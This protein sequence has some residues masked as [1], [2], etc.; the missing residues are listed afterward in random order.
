MKQF[1]RVLGVVAAMALLNTPLAMAQEITIATGKPGGGYD[2]RARDMA[3]R[4]EQ[5][6]LDITVTNYNGSDEISLAVCGN[7]AQIGLMQI[8]AIYA[9][10]LEGCQMRP[11][12]LYG[13]E[14]AVLL[15]PPRSGLDELGDMN[16]SHAVLVDTIG[17]GTDLFWRTI[18]SIEN[19]DDGTKDDW[20]KARP[21]NDL[22][23]LAHT[24]ATLGSIHAV[25]LVRRPDS[26]DI[27]RLLELGWTLGELW[28]RDINDL[29]FNDGELYIAED[30]DIRFRGRD[31]GDW[32][33]IVR[34]F[35]VTR[36]EIANGDRQVFAAIAAA[37]Q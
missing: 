7:R 18:V 23:E 13:Q 14:V 32:G 2:G 9:R 8:D 29:Q 26:P 11:V 37:A 35:I 34:S 25:L 6:G 20:A 1:M 30:L 15:F 24:Q 16:A 17:S 22:L 4:L 27:T 5:R 19:G 3:T 28:D 12:G 31:V 33:Y 21:V 36:P 10:S